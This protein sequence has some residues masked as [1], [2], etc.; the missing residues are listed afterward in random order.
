LLPN[1]PNPAKIPFVIGGSN[2][3]AV[4]VIGVWGEILNAAY[5]IGSGAFPNNDFLLDHKNIVPATKWAFK[6][7]AMI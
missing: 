6:V 1:F 5:T 2:E 3:W 4:D 7:G